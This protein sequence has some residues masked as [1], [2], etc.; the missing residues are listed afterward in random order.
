VLCEA[1]LRSQRLGNRLADER[2]VAQR[3]Q[4]DPEDACLVGRDERCRRLERESSLPRPA[5]ARQR[6]KPCAAD[7]GEQLAQLT[8]PADERARGTREVRIRD[9]LQRREALAAEL[10]DRDR[11]RDVLQAMLAEIGER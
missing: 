4:A 2:R 6:H 10:E 11:S 7:R 1:V 9:R 5:R 8:L 3:G